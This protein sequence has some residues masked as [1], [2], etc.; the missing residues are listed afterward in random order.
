MPN[1]GVTNDAGFL[2]AALSALARRNI[3]AMTLEGG[4]T[5]QQS[6]WRAGLVDRVELFV[7]PH[8]LGTDGV[9]WGGL[10]GG[11]VVFLDELSASPIGADVR[12]EG[13]VHRA[14]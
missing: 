6:F 13:Y 10:P 4:P 12:I 11:S 2:A 9:E 1:A 7:S 8:A 5:L 3:M 14:G